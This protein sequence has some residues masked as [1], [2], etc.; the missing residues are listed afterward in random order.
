MRTIPFALFAL[1][2]TEG[3]GIYIFLNSLKLFA[4]LQPS[5]EMHTLRRYVSFVS[6]RIVCIDVSFQN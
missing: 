1:G 3:I 5:L 4:I 6:Y 2:T